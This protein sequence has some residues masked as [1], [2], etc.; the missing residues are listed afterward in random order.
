[1]SVF[2]IIYVCRMWHVNSFVWNWTRQAV[3]LQLCFC[4]IH[5][6]PSLLESMQPIFLTDTKLWPLTSEWTVNYLMFLFVLVIIFC[7][8]LFLT[9]VWHTYSWFLILCCF[10]WIF[11]L[12]IGSIFHHF[13]SSCC[14]FP[15]ISRFSVI[16]IFVILWRN[17]RA[18]ECAQTIMLP[19][20]NCFQDTPC[21][22]D[23]HH[24]LFVGCLIF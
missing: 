17:N 23:M 2:G 12:Y 13:V 14:S 5:R 10:V 4:D 8:L 11:H 18:R 1:M 19:M 15:A 3:W 9:G 24:Y 6:A 22:I 7:L 21:C 16:F 20:Q